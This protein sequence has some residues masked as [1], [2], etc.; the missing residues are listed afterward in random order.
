VLRA[1]RQAF[2]RLSLTLPPPS[3]VRR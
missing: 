1:A 2:H 3:S